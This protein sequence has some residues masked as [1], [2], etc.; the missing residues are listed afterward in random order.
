M[1]ENR[2]QAWFRFADWCRGTL[3]AGSDAGF[4]IDKDCIVAS[5]CLARRRPW[6]IGTEVPRLPRLQCEN[7][8]YHVITRGDGRRRLFQCQSVHSPQPMQWR[9]AA[10]R[11]T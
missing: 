5:E 3:R 9:P 8:I 1:G 11:I 7:A 4:G 6:K 2:L 10:G